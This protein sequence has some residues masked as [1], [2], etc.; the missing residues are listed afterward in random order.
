MLDV[1]DKPRAGHVIR[2][3]VYGPDGMERPYYGAILDGSGA[4][5]SWRIPF[6]L[7]DSAGEWQ[8]SATDVISGRRAKASIRLTKRPG[9]HAR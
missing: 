6:A 4:G 5:Q 1:A 8:I 3:Q 9:K 2:V 7:N